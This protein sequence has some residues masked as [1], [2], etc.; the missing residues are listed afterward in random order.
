LEAEV[1][2]AAIPH[3]FRGEEGVYQVAVKSAVEKIHA[4]FNEERSRITEETLGNGKATPDGPP[5][6]P[7]G[8]I[9]GLGRSLIA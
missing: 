4:S 7:A 5:E 1:N 8:V 6:A 2:S 3:H 9:Q